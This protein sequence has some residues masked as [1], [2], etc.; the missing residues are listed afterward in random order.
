MNMRLNLY[1]LA[2]T[3][4]TA[5]CGGS[6]APAVAGQAGTTS[7]EWLDSARNFGN[8]NEGQKLAV[9]FR[10]RNT[11]NKPLIIESVKPTCGC[12]VAE[13][14]KE[15]I[16]PGEEGEI[17]GAFDSN[18]REG[19]QRKHITVTSNTEPAVQDVSFEVNVVARPRAAQNTN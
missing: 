15:P 6:D 10:F 14:P 18:G 16:A 1:L 2:F 5:A 13:Y 9:S 8:I 3:L 17:T 4:C 11:G 7:I 19:F 12:T